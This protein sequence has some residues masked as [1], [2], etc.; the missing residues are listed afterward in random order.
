M[1]D[2]SEKRKPGANNMGIGTSA[3]KKL[4][5]PS[6]ILFTL[7]ISVTGKR[8][9][10]PHPVAYRRASFAAQGEY[11]HKFISGYG[12]LSRVQRKVGRGI[13]CENLNWNDPNRN[14]YRDRKRFYY[15]ISVELR[16]QSR[17]RFKRKTARELATFKPSGPLV[18]RCIQ[19]AL[20]HHC[21]RGADRLST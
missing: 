4:P 11:I 15:N 17:F 7:S 8:F 20:E 12:Y 14:R 5:D 18:L 2:G 1:G 3:G 21:S 6:I 10:Y 16:F 19:R 13:A 9:G